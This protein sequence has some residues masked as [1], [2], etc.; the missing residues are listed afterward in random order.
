MNPPSYSNLLLALLLL[1]QVFVSF[2]EVRER[3]AN[4]EFVGVDRIAIILLLL[5]ILSPELEVFIGTRLLLID[6]QSKQWQY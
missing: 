2:Q 4:V 6:L 1:C 5:H 3:G